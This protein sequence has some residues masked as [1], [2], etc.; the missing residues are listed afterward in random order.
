M[1]TTPLQEPKI[2]QRYQQLLGARLAE[3]DSV[4][5]LSKL[6]HIVDDYETRYGISSE[7]LHDAIEARELVETLDVGDRRFHYDRM[8]RV[9]AE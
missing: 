3:V 7:R 5:M 1:A 9:D 6:R 8:Y 4:T 2:E